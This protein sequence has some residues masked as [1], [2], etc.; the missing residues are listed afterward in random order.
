MASRASPSNYRNREWQRRIARR[1]RVPRAVAERVS[2]SSRVRFDRR[3]DLALV[4]ADWDSRSGLT[5]N[6]VA[7]LY[8]FFGVEPEQKEWGGAWSSA[9]RSEATRSSVAPVEVESS[10]AKWGGVAEF[11]APPNPRPGTLGNDECAGTSSER[12]PDT[13]HCE[14]FKTA[15]R[16]DVRRHVP[17]DHAQNSRRFAPSFKKGS[18]REAAT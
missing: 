14:Q 10:G 18:R 3:C 5:P 15:G 12:C 1:V 6:S 17:G 2:F 4:A 9:I 11:S 13:S 7:S 16:R 8:E